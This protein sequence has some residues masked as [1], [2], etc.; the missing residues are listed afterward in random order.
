MKHLNFFLT[1]TLF[2]TFT[3]SLFSQNTLLRLDDQEYVNMVEHIEYLEDKDQSLSIEE[4]QNPELDDQ[5]KKS[6]R[7]ILNFGFSKSAYW[8]RFQIKAKSDMTRYLLIENPAS[9][10]IGFFESSNGKDFTSR[11]TGDTMPFHSRE[12]ANR[13]FII[14]MNIKKDTE[15][16]YFIRLTNNGSFFVPV[17]LISPGHFEETTDRE[18]LFYGAYYGVMLVMLILSFLIWTAFKDTSYL[19]FALYIGVLVVMQFV[20]DG[21]AFQF[22]WPDTPYFANKASVFF[23]MLTNLTFFQFIRTFLNFKNIRPL[24]DKAFIVLII[25]TS[26]AVPLTFVHYNTAVKVAIVINFVMPLAVLITSTILAFQK[27]HL[28]RYFIPAFAIFLFAM[29]VRALLYSG[30]IDKHPITYY[31]LHYGSVTQIVILSMALVQRINTIRKE[32]EQ[33]QKMMI[34]HQKEALEA[35]SKLNRAYARFVPQQFLQFLNKSS[36]EEVQLGDS[37]EKTMTVLFLDIRSFTQISEQMQP[38]ENFRFLNAIYRRISPIIRKHHGFVDKYI[39]DAVM[40]LFPGKPDDAVAAAVE[41]QNMIKRLSKVRTRMSLEPIKV[42]I[43]IHLGSLMLGTIGEPERMEGTVIADAV[44]LASRIEGLTKKYRVSIMISEE[45]YNSLEDK[46]KFHIR[47]IDKIQAKGKQ[48][49]VTLYEVFDGDSPEIMQKKST[50]S[51][52]FN[53]GVEFLLQGDKINAI[54]ALKKSLAQ[55]PEDITA[56]VLIHLAKA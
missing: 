30:A 32:S 50:T 36:I 38:D 44:N 52:L 55:F 13:N 43:G 42:G 19:Y 18:S 49:F 41:M 5:F 47:K 27:N 54:E 51:A 26:V 23:I 12:I 46:S 4:V 25:I 17:Y 20:I 22:L 53:S 15:Y 6:T 14:K 24:I 1:T 35:Q 3:T 9:D 28:A 21:Y 56:K 33:N 40:A 31:S 45:M 11:L 8:L 34:L 48:S 29:V 16:S 2:F 37:I 10:H 7:D 39:G